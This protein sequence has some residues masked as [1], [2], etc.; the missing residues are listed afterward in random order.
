MPL[1]PKSSSFR[2]GGLLDE[3]II[4]WMGE[5]GRTPQIN[6]TAGREHFPTVVPI[7]IGGGGFEEGQVIGKNRWRKNNPGTRVKRLPPTTHY[8]E[9]S[10]LEIFETERVVFIKRDFFFGR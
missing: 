3:T 5:F 1:A 6:A 10:T 4:L 9:G 7:A 2:A 8:D